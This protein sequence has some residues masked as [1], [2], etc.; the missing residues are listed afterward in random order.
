M[1]AQRAAWMLAFKAE[2]SKHGGDTFVQ[3][4]L[5]LTK[6]FEAV[7]HQK[8]IDAAHKRGYSTVLLRLSLAAYRL[9]R[10]V[11]LAGAYADTTVAT[12]GI[13]AGSGFATTELRLLM[14][15]VVI[16][17]LEEWGIEIDLTLYVD[18]LT[19]AAQGCPRMAAKKVALVVN[20][21]IRKIEGEFGMQVSA[22]K[23]VVLSSSLEAARHAA[24]STAS[25]KLS[26]VKAAKLLGTATTAGRARCTKVQKHRIKTFKGRLQRFEQL[27]K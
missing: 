21:V 27:R 5:D 15:E 6:A 9:K 24:A 1:G 8:L 22:K 2:A 20:Q 16:P 10:S 11:G 3:A 12:R 17:I 23:S 19:I 26:P 4:M 14:M 7:P 25:K 13:T 18:D